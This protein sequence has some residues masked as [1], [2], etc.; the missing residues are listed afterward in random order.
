MKTTNL[1]PNQK[2]INLD[3]DKL[4]VH[5]QAEQALIIW[6]RL[7]LSSSSVS[8]RYLDKFYCPPIRV[9]KNSSDTYYF[10]NDFER[11]NDL[12]RVRD[13]DSYP[14][15]VTPESIKDIQMLAWAEVVQ[16][17]NLKNINHPDLFKAL[18]QKAP[19]SVI[20]KLMRID[21]LSVESY[22]KFAGIKKANFEYQQC[23]K[24]IQ[25][26]VIGIPKNMDWLVN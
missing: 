11:V 9:I 16:L 14:C 10:I 12:L 7:R 6:Q 19:S 5:P 26:N 1:K 2:L 23:R 21:I 17:V 24:A 25:N 8:I 18:K 15:L 3:R 4:I 13:V 20:C 22:C